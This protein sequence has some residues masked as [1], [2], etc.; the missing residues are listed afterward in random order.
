M[1]DLEE[2]IK[3]EQAWEVEKEELGRALDELRD[4][5]R[6]R[7]EEAERA[8]PGAAERLEWEERLQASEERLKAIQ[9]SRLDDYA[10]YESKREEMKRTY[11]GNVADLERELRDW[12]E[13]ALKAEALLE[14][15][16]FHKQ[17]V[18]GGGME[19]DRRSSA[20]EGGH[21]LPSTPTQHKTVSRL[22]GGGGGGPPQSSLNVNGQVR[23]MTLNSGKLPMDDDRKRPSAS[24]SS[25][26]SSSSSS[27]DALKR[28]VQQKDIRI[29]ALEREMRT[30]RITADEAAARSAELLQAKEEVVR[31][32]VERE[33]LKDKVSY[34]KKEVA[35]VQAKVEGL[36]KAA[37]A[38][39]KA[40]EKAKAEAK[41]TAGKVRGMQAEKA[42]VAMEK[43]RMEKEVE[44][45]K[46][47]KATMQAEVERLKGIEKEKKEAVAAAE[48]ARRVLEVKEEELRLMG[49]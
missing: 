8:T 18:G 27:A 44:G 35:A 21:V 16:E 5:R 19:E 31:V 26:S 24:T 2:S 40:T 30:L 23:R 47:A 14:K 4:E 34:L 48:R 6:A 7:E 33:G 11:E 32:G 10:L 25:S 22:G 28:D 46:K 17:I 38:Q 39:E 36:V 41:A 43:A 3:R 12:N 45:M 20:F 49:R 42:Q 13:R 37:K 9:L 1:R 29:K 15:Y